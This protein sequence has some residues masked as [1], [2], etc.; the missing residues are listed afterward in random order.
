MNQIFTQLFVLLLATSLTLF[1]CRKD[2]EGLADTDTSLAQKYSTIEQSNNDL[3]ALASEIVYTKNTSLKT[4]E[5]S[6][7]L[8]S[9]ATIDFNYKSNDSINAEVNFGDN[10]CLCNDQKYRRGKVKI[11]Y[12]KASK[13][14]SLSTENY[15]VNNNKI[16]V[17]R[18][19]KYILP[20]YFVINASASITFADSSQTI[21]ENSTRT[22]NWTEGSSTSSD[23]TDDV[24]LVSGTG[25]GVN[26]NGENYTV[27]IASPLKRTGDCSYI[28]SGK[29]EIKPGNKLARVINFGDG[30][31]DD[32]AT[33]SIGKYSKIIALK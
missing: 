14:I 5:T 3:D 15:Y 8:L 9:C 28:R 29:I 26:H 24:F 4:N 32:I 21:T 31:C 2:R 25:S 12:G 18:N 20:T 22:I 17:S 13:S 1:S 6:D 30:D 19:L 23:K 10:N 7:A 11:V 33:I 16:E 27:N